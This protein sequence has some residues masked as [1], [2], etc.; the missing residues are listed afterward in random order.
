M[1]DNKRLFD[2]QKEF[3]LT[4]ATKSFA[5]RM[6]QINR[7]ERLLIENES[8]LRDALGK[9]FKT[10]WFEQTMEYGATL[11]SIA[12]TKE[13]LAQWMIP[14]EVPLSKRLMDSGHKGIIFREPFGV[15]LIVAPFNAPI[16][17]TFDPL[18]AALSAGN[19]AII[20]PSRVT[21]NTSALI[22]E[23]VARYFDPEAVT[24]ITGNRT[25]L[26]ELLSFPFD[27]MFFTGSTDVGKVVMR[28]AAE[29]LTP[30]LA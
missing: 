28:A 18:I 27:F 4:N 26:A 7:L 22:E 2:R 17:L 6:D 21:P 9:D 19:T 14:E 1:T 20:K 8:A 3:F 24:V 25:V 15:C 23:L 12:D 10:A 11:G 30:C 13:R 29:H 16:A 5:W